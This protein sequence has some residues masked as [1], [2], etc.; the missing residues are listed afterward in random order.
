MAKSRPGAPWLEKGAALQFAGSDSYPQGEGLT[1][2]EIPD[3]ALSVVLPS[4]E[5]LPHCAR[6]KPRTV[7]ADQE[8]LSPQRWLDL[9]TAWGI[10][11]PREWQGATLVH[12]IADDEPDDDQVQTGKYGTQ[13]PSAA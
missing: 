6:R 11:Q 12:R 7:A 2:L 8:Q 1:H 10:G 13:P 3:D 5:S 4:D 9:L